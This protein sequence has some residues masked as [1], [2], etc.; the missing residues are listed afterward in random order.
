VKIL[1]VD[2]SR[3]GWG[4][5]QHLVSLA[6]ALNAN[7][8]SIAAVVKERSPVANLLVA[9]GIRTY[10]TPFRGGADP[11]GILATI[12]AVVRESPD[13]IVT[14]RAKLYWTVWIIGRLMG[15]PVTLFR[16]MAELRPWLTRRVLPRLADRFIVVSEFARRHLAARG[17]PAHLIHVLYNPVDISTRRSLRIRRGISRLRLGVRSDDFLIGFVGR[18]EL[19]KGIR[20][21]WAALVPLMARS[22]RVRFLCVG[23]GPELAL[24]RHD[25]A[26][27]GLSDRCHFISWTPCVE[28]FYPAMD[29]LV[30]P[31]V[32]A[33]TFCRVIA[34]AQASEV[35]VIGARVGGIPEAFLPDRSGLLVPPD[36]WRALSHAIARLH[37]DRECRA[38]FGATGRR[39]AKQQFSARQV[40]ER[41]VGV[42]ESSLPGSRTRPTAQASRPRA[43]ASVGS[44]HIA[45][46]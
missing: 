9:S 3:N 26:V 13:W 33:E 1:F 2:A 28:D 25:V 17:A 15:V 20:V 32:N 39:Y 37:D 36:D 31:S 19:Q 45:I 41:F 24:W 35:A 18:V 29:L 7:G 12:R 5:E 6:R 4:T 21:L 38:R 22:P 42:L 30:A 10:A 16:H 27:A 11:R 34:E 40:A 8:H 23:D 46:R 14:S 43:A 44:L